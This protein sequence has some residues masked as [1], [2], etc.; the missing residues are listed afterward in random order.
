MKKTSLTT[1]C[2]RLRSQSSQMRK[3]T[4]NPGGLRPSSG[5][6][7]GQCAPFYSQTC[8]RFQDKIR[9]LPTRGGLSDTNPAPQSQLTPQG[10]RGQPAA[11]A[12]GLKEPRPTEQ[13]LPE[14]LHKDPNRSPRGSTGRR[15]AVS[16]RDAVPSPAR[17]CSRPAPSLRSAS[18]L[19]TP[20]WQFGGSSCPPMMPHPPL[21]TAV[22]RSTP[23]CDEK[24]GV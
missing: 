16:A 13:L 10:Q 1:K 14:W 11:S 18:V 17:T 9:G 19:E 7:C 5:P 12:G 23:H 21:N 3:A 20:T 24:E 8:S 15:R 22:L 2:R 4:P 6:T